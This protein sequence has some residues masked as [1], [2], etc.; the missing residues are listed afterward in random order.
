M[1]SLLQP[2]L[3]P[4]RGKRIETMRDIIL[5]YFQGC[6]PTVHTPWTSMVGTVQVVVVGS[7]CR[8][9]E[10]SQPAAAQEAQLGHHVAPPRSLFHTA[11]GNTQAVGR[12]LRTLPVSPGRTLPVSAN[13]P[14][15]GQTKLIRCFAEVVY[16]AAITLRRTPDIKYVLNQNDLSGKSTMVWRL[17]K[18]PVSSVVVEKSDTS[19][20]NCFS[21][22]ENFSCVE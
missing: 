22:E 9:Y 12:L 1:F 19:F 13:L 2:W 18:L 3:Q 16:I 11:P 21:C 20:S 8:D 17:G 14:Q 5:A 4:G 7:H 15:L 10:D 6:I